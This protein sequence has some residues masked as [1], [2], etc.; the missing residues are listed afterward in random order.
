MHILTD[1][2]GLLVKGKAHPADIQDRDG[3]RLRL[4]SDAR[5]PSANRIQGIH[6]HPVI[7]DAG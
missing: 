5:V 3:V 6:S 4:G 7:K 1:K 2:Q